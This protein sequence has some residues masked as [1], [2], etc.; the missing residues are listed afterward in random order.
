MVGG[1]DK[2]PIV[3]TIDN[4][5]GSLKAGLVNSTLDGDAIYPETEIPNAVA[6]SRRGGKAAKNKLLIGKEI[7]PCPEYTMTR[8]SHKGVVIDWETEKIIWDAVIHGRR[9]L[10]G[11]LPKGT[12][13]SE[14]TVLVSQPL[15]CPVMVTRVGMQVLFEDFGFARALFI[16]SPIC[17]QFSQGITSQFGDDEWRNPCGLI[18][19][20]GFSGCR[21]VPVYNTYP[22]EH[23]AQRMDVGGRVMTNYL[24]EALAYNQVDLDDA[25]LLVEHIREN[26][27]YSALNFAEEVQAARANPSETIRRYVL[28]DHSSSSSHLGR[29]VDPQIEEGNSS[30]EFVDLNHERMVIC[31]ALWQPGSIGIVQ[32]G[33]GEMAAGAVMKAPA[34]TRSAVA[35]KVI[36]GGGLFLIPG[37]LERFKQEFK[38]NLPDD[39]ASEVRFFVEED[40]RY[41]LSV[42][43]GL[44]TLGS[45]ET[46]MA[47]LGLF[48]RDAWL[49][50]ARKAAVPSGT[51]AS[52]VISLTPKSGVSGFDLDRFRFCQKACA[53][54][55]EVIRDMKD[56]EEFCLR[57]CFKDSIVG[58]SNAN[59]NYVVLDR[60]PGAPE[61][62]AK[63]M[64]VCTTGCG[65]RFGE[66]ASG[67]WK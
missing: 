63:C 46:D 4:G 44:H 3:V 38:S 42:W 65:F 51:A 50:A 54:S 31:E 18:V 35:K 2:A 43:R 60:S 58:D 15:F 62:S 20:A 28:P 61:N 9:L 12:D 40:G 59:A 17:L 6:R 33:L 8:P 36:L 34:A 19:D 13:L 49:K 56:C 10:P 37:V 66:E 32:E 45:S 47:Q 1:G 29:V 53:A 26:M 25:P 39:I 48:K 16:D 21:A 22:L 41:D 64:Q 11:L 30:G 7:T 5:G 57:L 24:K 27:C 67:D 14:V 55:D 23:C 52:D